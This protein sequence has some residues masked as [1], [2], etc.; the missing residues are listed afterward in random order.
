MH[1][2][3]VVA[4]PGDTEDICVAVLTQRDRPESSWLGNTTESFTA[5]EDPS[6]TYTLPSMANLRN[7]FPVQ[8]THT[9]PSG[10]NAT[11]VGPSER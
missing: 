4:S 11:P 9:E 5:S 7:A 2:T 3:A 8:E 6:I 1:R 10:A